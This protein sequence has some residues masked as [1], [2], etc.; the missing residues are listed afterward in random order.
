MSEIESLPW[1]E[2]VGSV[3]WRQGEHVSLIGP[4]GAGKTTLALELL[5]KRKFVVV[6][7]TKPKDPTLSKLKTKGFEVIRK[8]PD[9]VS[10]EIHPK[11][12]LWPT[13][14]KPGDAKKQQREVGRALAEIFTQGGWTVYADELR[15]ISGTL[16]LSSLLELIWQQGRS[17]GISLV[18]GTQRPAHV[19]LMVYDQATHLFFWRDNDE[20]NLKRIGGLGRLDSKLIRDTVGDLPHHS[21]LYLNTRTGRMVVTKVDLEE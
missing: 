19:P 1:N 21:T 3:K 4:T 13:M 9:H 7:G 2:F 6:L 11:L 18:G 10:T 12:I 15:Y 8:W 20:A 17:L 14:R 16:K 5:P